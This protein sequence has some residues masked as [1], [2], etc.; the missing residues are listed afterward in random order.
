M[1]KFVALLKDAHDTLMCF[2]LVKLDAIYIYKLTLIVIIQQYSDAKKAT[3]IVMA[4]L[5]TYIGSI[6]TLYVII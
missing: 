3:L 1:A 6:M 5:D 4:I 2:E